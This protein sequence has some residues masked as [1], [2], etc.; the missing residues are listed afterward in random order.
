MQ[1]LESDLFT[2][3]L[4]VILAFIMKKESIKAKNAFKNDLYKVLKK[5]DFMPYKFRKSLAFDDE[6]VRDFIFKGYVIPYKIDKE[7]DLIII[8]GIYKENLPNF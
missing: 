5:L 8:L 3:E 6:S 2:N 4:N 7:K 1:I